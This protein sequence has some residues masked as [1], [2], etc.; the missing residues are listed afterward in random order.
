MGS[1]THYNFTVP[2]NLGDN[3]IWGLELNSTINAMDSSLWSA[4]AGVNQGVNTLSLVAS[5]ALT[6]PL[7][8]QQNIT[9][10]ANGYAVYMPAMNTVTVGSTSPNTSAPLVGSIVTFKNMSSTYNFSIF[11]YDGTTVIYGGHL[12]SGTLTSGGTGYV[13]GTYTDVPLTGGAGSG[14]TANITVNSSGIVTLVTPIQTGI[15]FIV[16]DVLSASNSYLG[17]SGSGLVF[18]VSS[19][20]GIAPGASVQLLVTSNS[21]VNGSFTYRLL[22]DVVSQN[23]LSDIANPNTALNNLLPDQNSNAGLVL[24]TNGTNASWGTASGFSTGDVK[25][26][27]KN[28]ADSGW[29][30]AD[31]GALATASTSLY[32]VYYSSINNGGSSFTVGDYIWCTGGAT[33]VVTSVSSGVITG[34]KQI[35]SGL[36]TSSQ[37]TVSQ[38]ATSGS[39]SGAILNVTSTSFSTLHTGTSY[40]ALYYLLWNNIPDI[41]CPVSGGR[42]STAAADWTAGK[43]IRITRMLGRVL[44]IA[45]S[46]L[47]LNSYSLGQ[48]YGDNNLQM[49]GHSVNESPHRHSGQTWDSSGGSSNTVT[50]ASNNGSTWYSDYATTGIT[51]NTAGSGYGQNMQPTT[52]LNAMIKL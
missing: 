39:G 3:G 24:V 6:S 36:Y 32:I 41:Y 26:T 31:D 50:R 7:V 10:N 12:G 2:N 33:F 46:G 30:L 27:L 52:F 18:T 38:S 19:T 40:Q 51:V 9:P 44:G 28:T 5:T 4:T 8:S 14:A 25:F 23:N 1:S 34:V 48:L 11:A 15:G 45:G 37:A 29:I 20:Y 17:G 49:H 13:A 21:T 35:D 16:G 43:A 22:G 47:N 42:G